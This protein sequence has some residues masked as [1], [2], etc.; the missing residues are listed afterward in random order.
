MK[1]EGAGR[2]TGSNHFFLVGVLVGSACGLVLGSALGFE[3]RP[4]RIRALKK[5]VRR[6][7]GQEDRPRFDLMV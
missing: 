2:G 7:T 3:L 5:M 1:A 6:L 4:D